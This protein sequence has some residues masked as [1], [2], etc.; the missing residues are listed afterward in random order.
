M[1][2]EIGKFKL[3]KVKRGGIALRDSNTRRIKK[4]DKETGWQKSQS[5][6]EY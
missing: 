3:L 5:Q 6:K 2:D 4:G 1:D